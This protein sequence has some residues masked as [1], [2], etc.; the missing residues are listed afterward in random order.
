MSENEDLKD[1]L[2]KEIADIKEGISTK[3]I[4]QLNLDLTEK[5]VYRVSSFASECI[6]CRNYMHKLEADLS[7]IMKVVYQQEKNPLK[8]YFTNSKKI[9]AH[10][11]QKHNLVTEGYYTSVYMSIG[12][13]LG[14]PFGTAFSQVMGNMAF[15]GIG[16]PIGLSIGLSIGA[17]LDAKAKKDGLLI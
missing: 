5:I 15:I 7:D 1:L 2:I 6:E 8:D 3:R 11:R 10:L 12:I 17:G 16:L 9:T 13:A 14:L 4:K